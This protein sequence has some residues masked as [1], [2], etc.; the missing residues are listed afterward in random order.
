MFSTTFGKLKNV[1]KILDRIKK[2]RKKEI[3]KKERKKEIDY[4]ERKEGRKT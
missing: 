4:K 2:E 1:V 3:A